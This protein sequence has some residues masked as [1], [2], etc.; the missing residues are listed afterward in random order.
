MKTIFLGLIGLI[1]GGCAG[2]SVEVMPRLAMLDSSGNFGISS[3][4]T[5]A[6]NDLSDL[7]LDQGDDSVVGARV[8]AD[9]LV[10]HLILSG[11]SMSLS[12]DGALTGDLSQGGTTISAG[13]T[14]TSS[15]DFDTLSLYGTFDFLPTQMFELGLGLGVTGLQMQGD[16]AEKAVPTNKVSFD[17]SF[18]LPVIA[19]TGAVNV[20]SLGAS[21]LLAGMDFSH[22]GDSVTYT[23]IDLN[24][25]WQFVD[26]VVNAKLFLGWRQIATDAKFQSSGDDVAVDVTFS[27]PYLGISVG[28]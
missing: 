4:G 1:C 27:G 7:G 24:A 12:G 6:H 16:I 21:L 26:S 23:D 19:V 5:V 8:D 20:G 9:V 15:L 22:S 28:I 2:A 13:T 11:L 3:T 10:A 18:A 17:E 14:V 25:H